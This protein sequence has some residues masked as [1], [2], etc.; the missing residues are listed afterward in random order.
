MDLFHLSSPRPPFGQ[1]IRRTKAAL[2]AAG[3]LTIIGADTSFASPVDEARV[4]SVIAAI[5]VYADNQDFHPLERF[6]APETTIDY[7]SLWGG[8]PQ[9]FAPSALMRAWAGLLPGFD[10]TRHELSDIQVRIGDNAA[11]AQAKVRATHWLGDRTWVVAGAYD[12]ALVRS[13]AGWQVS[14][15]TLRLADESGDRKLVEEAA[16]KVAGTK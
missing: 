8:E 1:K 12:Y 9:R 7:T 5:A 10:A 3:L 14:R 4:A 2:L 6:F 16:A 11:A 13:E 15:M